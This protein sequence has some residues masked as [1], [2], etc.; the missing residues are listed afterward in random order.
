MPDEEVIKYTKR[1]NF[2]I[3]KRDKYFNHL[4]HDLQSNYE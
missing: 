1:H 3:F 2:V 4:D